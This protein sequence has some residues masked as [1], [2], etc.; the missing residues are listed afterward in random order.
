MPICFIGI[1]SNLGNRKENIKAA[2]NSLRKIKG[3]K[4]EKISS[5]YQTKPE[6]VINQND[7]INGVMRIKTNIPPK[8]LINRLKAIEKGLGRKETARFG[9]RVIDLDILL[10]DNQRINT[11]NL[12]LPHQRMYARDFVLIPLRD[13]APEMFKSKIIKTVPGMR[14]FVKEARRKNYTIGFVPTMG[15]LHEGHLSLVREAKKDCDKVVVSIF[16]N[17]IQFGPKE[18]FRRYPRDLRQDERMLKR[19]G[20]DAIFYPAVKEIYPA[21]Y[22]T[23]VNVE[24]ITKALCGSFRPGHFKGVATIVTKLFN[25][26][27]PDIA[28]FGQKDFQQ[29]RVIEKITQ[30]LNIPVKI[31][32]MPVVREPDGLAMSSR[33][34]Y[35]SDKERADAVALYQSLSGARSLIKEGERC[36]DRAI[37]FIRNKIEKIKSARIDYIE[38]VD[39]ENL[40]RIEKISG[41]V[42]IALAVWFGKTRLIDNI[43][44]RVKG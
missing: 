19:I 37:T 13:V 35:L 22:L 26:M 32:V 14:V 15:F 34:I 40:E 5:F 7:F 8:K 44:M 18:D 2:I 33:N 20:V 39:T 3:V 6:G 28:Y 10:Y 38:I 43:I 30:D 21:N 24:E 29:A 27:E 9:P 25:I 4:I 41:R 11:K 1:G 36:P 42:L 31:K 17:P 12:T 16:V 23:Y